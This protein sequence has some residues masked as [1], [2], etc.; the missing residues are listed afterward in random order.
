MSTPI[1]VH[2]PGGG[3][4]PGGKPSP[5]AAGGGGLAGMLKQKPAAAAAVGGVLL[6]VVVAMARKGSGGGGTPADQLQMTGGGSTYDS[7]AND[8]YNS[9]QPQ[10]DA[11][12]KMMQE[13]QGKTPTPSTPTPPVIKP[14]VVRPPPP[15]VV[16]PVPKPVQPASRTA[17]RANVPKPT[18]PKPAY[19]QIKSGDTLSG[20]AKKAGISMDRLKQL[21]PTFWSNP[22]YDKGN[23]IWSGGKVRTK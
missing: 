7:T 5:P 8:L 3:P 20:I 13:L 10:I 23:T 16:K 1:A 6:V 19:V 4:P 2:K 9:I 14:P 18:L 11:L 17:T 15:K 21:N 12:A 22:K